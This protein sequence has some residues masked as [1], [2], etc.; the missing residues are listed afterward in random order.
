MYDT[1]TGMILTP[2]DISKHLTD[3]YEKTDYKTGEVCLKGKAGNFSFQSNDSGYSF[4]GSLTK[5]KLNHNFSAITNKQTIE[6][7]EKISD[8]IHLNFNNGM[9]S[10]I[11]FGNCFPM[12]EK[13]EVYFDSL[14]YLNPYLERIIKKKTSLYYGFD[15]NRRGLI[16][17]D[18]QKEYKD[19]RRDIPPEYQQGN[20]LRY[21][22]KLKRLDSLKRKLKLDR[23]K[24]SDLSNPQ[25]FNHFL[26]IWKQL[27]LEIQKEPK[28]MINMNGQNLTWSDLQDLAVME[29][30]KNRGGISQFY[31][32]LDLET[33]RKNFKKG[34]FKQ[35]IK[36]R[37]N[38]ITLSKIRIEKDKLIN[39]LN[40][41]V[42]DVYESYKV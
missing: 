37:V 10:R 23:C 18:K 8:N 19:N 33:R 31:E 16:F 34:S 35:H 29:Y 15:N 39:E 13:P 36:K 27:Y 42:L 12:I 9:L 25:I 28:G 3:V 41:K 2:E 22:I 5:E 24:I 7:I 38:Q 6:T 20:F 11:D 26:E 40:S 17:Y 30:I 1:V 21:E 4:I 14:G 32:W